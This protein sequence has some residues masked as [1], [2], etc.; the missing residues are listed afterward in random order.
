[1]V[2]G[3]EKREKKSKTKDWRIK[4]KSIEIKGQCYD[5]A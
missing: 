3:L 4:P 5:I 1:M 2:K